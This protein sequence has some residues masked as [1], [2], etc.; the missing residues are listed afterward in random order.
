MLVSQVRK[1][2]AINKCMQFLGGGG[3][4]DKKEKVA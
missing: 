2:K 1:K 4:S 3:G